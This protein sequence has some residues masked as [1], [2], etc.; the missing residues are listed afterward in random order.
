MTTQDA[1]I[2]PTR[3]ELGYIPR[4]QRGFVISARFGWV[5]WRDV[6]RQAFY[7]A[8]ID[9][10]MLS[11]VSNPDDTD[12]LLVSG[13]LFRDRRHVWRARKI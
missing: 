6:S 10:D 5:F 2:A 13:L 12:V 8:L 9:R 11:A 7:S 1:A 3:L 4:Y